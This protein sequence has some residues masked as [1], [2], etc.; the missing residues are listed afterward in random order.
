MHMIG[1]GNGNYVI[2]GSGAADQQHTI[3]T[4]VMPKNSLKLLGFLQR[5]LR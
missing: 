3:H 4:E 1:H 5:V 2:S